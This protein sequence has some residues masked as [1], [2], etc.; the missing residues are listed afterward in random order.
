MTEIQ[1]NNI[2]FEIPNA[3]QAES[4]TTIEYIQ[5]IPNPLF[6][7]GWYTFP[8]Q[9][10]YTIPYPYIDQRVIELQ[11]KVIMLLE[12]NSRLKDQLIAK[13]RKR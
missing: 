13:S 5:T 11:N 2:M 3:P 10:S 6:V 4:N 8:S 9:F 1:T 12:E 7:S